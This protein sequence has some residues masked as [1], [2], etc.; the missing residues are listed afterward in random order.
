MTATL[1]SALQEKKKQQKPAASPKSQSHFGN[2]STLLG[3][4]VIF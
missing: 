2:Q 1:H 3:A 4:A